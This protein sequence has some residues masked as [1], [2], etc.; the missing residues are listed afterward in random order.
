MQRARPDISGVSAAPIEIQVVETGR[1]QPGGK[2]MMHD[3]QFDQA[4]LGHQQNTELGG[5][6]VCGWETLGSSNSRLIFKCKI[7]YP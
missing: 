7:E 6:L 4:L 1:S 3:A 5:R 2:A